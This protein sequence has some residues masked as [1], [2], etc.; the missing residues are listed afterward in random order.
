MHHIA[1]VFQ[2]NASQGFAENST[3]PL[4]A[5]D[6]PDFL[7]QYQKL[8]LNND[9]LFH[10]DFHYDQAGFR[11]LASPKHMQPNQLWPSNMKYRLYSRY[12]P[13]ALSKKKYTINEPKLFANMENSLQSRR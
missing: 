7:A 9:R 13:T 11:F 2:R 6:N 4:A 3:G 8:L 5:A 12:R 1:D 10:M